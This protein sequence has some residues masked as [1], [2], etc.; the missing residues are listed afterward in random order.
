MGASGDLER[1]KD[2]VLVCLDRVCSIAFFGELG[3]RGVGLSVRVLDAL[4]VLSTTT[5]GF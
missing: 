3:A 5:T 1:F 4:L 2:A